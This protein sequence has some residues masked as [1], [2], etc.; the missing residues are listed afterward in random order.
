[1]KHTILFVCLALLLA[2]ATDASAEAKPKFNPA[3][4]YLYSSSQSDR[5][6]IDAAR[7]GIERAQRELNTKVPEYRMHSTDD[8]TATIKNVADSGAS[9]IIA[10]GYQNV[11]PVLNI[12]ERYPNTHFTVIDGLV[13]PLYP[14]VQSII[15]KDHEGAFLVGMIAAKVA[16]D[17]HIG[18]IGGM[19]IPLIRNFSQGFAQGARYAKPDI[20]IDVDMVGN[21]PE[22]WSNPEKAHELALKQ[23]EGGA[24]VVFAAAGGSGL[25]VLEAADHTGKYAIGVD[26]NQNGLYPGHVLTSMVK[27]VDIAVY[28]TLKTSFEGKW[29]PGIKYLGIREG[30]LDYA[31]DNNNRNLISEKLIEDVAMAKERIINGVIDVEMYSPK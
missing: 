3:I 11:M 2:V 9:P 23:F 26:T 24:D 4:V 6:F 29:N 21:G 1:M 25:G 30:A 27:R 22:A 12:A 17:D 28:D 20:R 7:A 15:F 31:V 8:I 14:N 16:G 5:A 13:P 19:D 18:F 10:V